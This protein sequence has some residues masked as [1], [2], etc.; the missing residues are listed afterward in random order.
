[1]SLESDGKKKELENLDQIYL[2]IVLVIKF[3]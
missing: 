3:N 2:K 1:M